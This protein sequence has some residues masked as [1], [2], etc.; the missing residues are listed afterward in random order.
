VAGWGQGNSGEYGDGTFVRAACSRGEVG[1]RNRWYVD[2]K[3]PSAG[4]NV[5]DYDDIVLFRMKRAPHLRLVRLMSC[6]T[7]I[8]G[9]VVLCMDSDDAGVAAIERLCIG[10]NPILVAAME[11]LNVDIYVASLPEGVKDPADFLEQHRNSD[12]LEKKFRVDVVRNALEW[13][14]WYMN[15]LLA[16]HD[17]DAANEESC[18]F[19]G[20]FERLAS[21]LAT[22]ENKGELAKRASL[23]ASKL[24]KLIK[25]DNSTQPI[26]ASSTVRIQLESD[27]VE[28]AASIT[29]SRF[30]QSQR[31]IESKD[32]IDRRM[33][34][35]NPKLAIPKSL[36][37]SED[38]SLMEIPWEGTKETGSALEGPDMKAVEPSTQPVEGRRKRPMRKQRTRLKRPSGASR[39]R[40]PM[41]RHIG[42]LASN[43]MDESWLGAMKEMVRIC[44]T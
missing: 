22:F 2:Q 28:M 32:G 31:R 11:N 25:I 7:N 44:A 10:K 17:P 26:E 16:S 39:G 1:S 23:V 30:I 24:A 3:L 14:E 40:N 37:F 29:R 9:R 18:S 36:E 35:W 38:P 34:S 6:L 21:F 13:S 19:N 12:H 42:G 20:V 5:S 8:T 15:R 33:G 41:T 27:L 43:V 4:G